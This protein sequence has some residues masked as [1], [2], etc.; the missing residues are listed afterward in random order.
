MPKALRI[1]GTKFLDEQGRTVHLRGVNLSGS[2]KTPP[3]EPTQIA[4]TFSHHREVSFVGRPFPLEDANEHFSRLAHW[5]FNTLRF[6]TTWEA[7]E[8]AGRGQYDT[9]YLDYLTE[10]VDMAGDY[11]FYVFIDPHQDVWSRMTG[12]DGAPGWTLEAAGFDISRLDASDAAITMQRRYPDY[13]IMVWVDNYSRLACA[14]MFTLFFAGDRFAPNMEVDGLPIQ[15][16]LQDAF[17]V[18]LQQVAQRLKNMPHVIGYGPLNEPG[19]GF[20]G[21]TSLYQSNGFPQNFVE[22][23]AL[24]AMACGGGM[25]VDAPLVSYD[26]YYNRYVGDAGTATLNPDGISAWKET[27]LWWDLGVWGIEDG[28]PV[29]LQE[30]YFADADFLDDA[31]LPFTQKYADAILS[32]DP[33]AIIF[34][35]TVPTETHRLR[36]ID[37]PPDR[38]VNAGHWYDEFMLFTRQFDGNRARDWGKG[39]EI[40]EGRENVQATFNDG[41]AALVKTSEKAMGGIPTL[42]GEFG[43]SYD[44]NAKSALK[45]GEFS[46]HELALSMYYDAIDTHLVHST[47]WNYTPDNSNQWGDNWNGE[48]LSIFSPDQ[49]EDEDDLNSGGRAIRGF[50]RPYVHTAAGTLLRRHFDHETGDFEAVINCNGSGETFVYVPAI[51]YGY[52]HQV[53]VSSGEWHETDDPQIIAWIC[54]KTGRQTIRISMG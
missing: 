31:L 2:T 50:C 54:E 22:V 17:I 36:P 9:A 37:A 21:L 16:Y 30:D 19:K 40:I 48:D 43:L 26:Q 49:Q 47:Q 42:I 35:E 6:L 4:N 46:L 8:H 51:W 7:I 3:D 41:I 12:G 14:T 1:Q 24:K 39:G 53:E 23:S 34:M 25:T 10:V 15:A 20:I 29:A 32:V 38:L 27:D 18:A 13:P 5:G 28:N 44:I 11:G 52:D 33:N 45:D